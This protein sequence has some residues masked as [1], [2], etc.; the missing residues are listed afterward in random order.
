MASI[1]RLYI[2]ILTLFGGIS[3]F[4]WPGIALYAIPLG[5][6][7]NMLGHSIGYHRLL[8][9]NSFEPRYA[10]IPQVLTLLG[11]VTGRGSPIGYAAI[12]LSHHVHSDSDS[13]PHSPVNKNFIQFFL[14]H[15]NLSPDP[16]ITVKVIRSHG[17][18]FNKYV[19]R[20]VLL[21]NLLT[22]TCMVAL[23]IAH[24]YAMVVFVTLLIGV[25]VNYYGH[26][27]AGPVDRFWL[28]IITLG[29]GFHGSHHQKPG[30]MQ[31]HKYDVGGH[32]CKWMS[33]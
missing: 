1:T 3:F 21:L 10:F 14:E 5:M 2:T 20:N 16:K 19:H 4:I 9:H 22:M 23:G 18:Q 31:F 7:V 27:T 28:G 13:D 15:F 8:T 12:H 25:M 24:I 11:C 30:A 17:T 33:K 6:L 29:E 26:D 32:L